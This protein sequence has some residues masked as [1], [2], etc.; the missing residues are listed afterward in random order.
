MKLKIRDNREA[1]IVRCR[2]WAYANVP[3]GKMK[4]AETIF[5]DT[6]ERYD[7]MCKEH[8]TDSHGYWSNF[9]FNQFCVDLARNL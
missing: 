3:I 9:Y 5:A 1:L 8:P 7:H 4:L 2:A 6:V